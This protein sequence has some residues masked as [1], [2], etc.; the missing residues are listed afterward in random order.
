MAEA[1]SRLAEGALRA[2]EALGGASLPL[3]ALAL[4]PLTL[5][6]LAKAWRWRAL[7]GP[8]RER[9]PYRLALRALVAGQVTNMVSP[10][11]AGAG[12]AVRLGVLAL[13]AGRETVVAGTG[14]LAGVK[15]LDTL[16]L[17]AIAF[18]VAGEAVVSGG[19]RWSVGP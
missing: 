5:V 13:V 17:G 4:A 11:R 1:W 2:V 7:F 9:V 16:C 3:L 8:H 10:L 19:L 18:G 15:A 14:A 6:E 12:E